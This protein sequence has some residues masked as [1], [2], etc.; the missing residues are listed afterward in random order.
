M[1]QRSEFTAP[2]AH[3]YDQRSAARW[4]LSH[5]RRYWYFALGFYFFF[6]IAWSCY[7]GAQVL[8]GRA[9][10]EVISPS[11]PNGLL[12]VAL[13][14]LA[15]LIGDGLS[16]LFGSLSAENVAARF[17]ADARQEL[18]DSLLGK[19]QTFHDR[20]RVGD[21]MARATD[22]VQPALEHDRPRGHHGLRDGHGHRHPADLHRLHP[23]GAAAGAALLRGI[24]RHHG[25]AYVRRLNPV[26]PRQ[27]EQFGKMNA[28]LEETISGIEVVKASAHEAFERE[29]VPPQR[30]RSSAT[31]LCEQGY[32]EAR[33]L[34]L[35]LFG[36]ALGL[37]FLHAMWLYRQR[38]ASSSAR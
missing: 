22:D 13:T 8:I 1:A 35:L 23:A 9:A 32:I 37:S 11:G 17:E 3:A 30:P 31:S 10:D 20:Q 27:R 25:E 21:I 26:V 34:P 28:G 15:V 33:Y 2:N 18:Y 4:V 14:I 7:S 19:S 12:I 38:R 29:Q 16:A 5:V 24:L 36:V 6:L